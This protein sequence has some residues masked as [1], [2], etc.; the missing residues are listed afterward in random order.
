ME[1]IALLVFIAIAL[2]GWGCGVLHD[3]WFDYCPTAD[4]EDA[5]N[6]ASHASDGELSLKDILKTNSIKGFEAI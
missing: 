6:S 3:K 2:L 5:F 4:E 1:I